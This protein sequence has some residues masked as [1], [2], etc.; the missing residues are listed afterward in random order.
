MSEETQEVAES[1]ETTTTDANQESNEESNSTGDGEGEAS[2]ESSEQRTT[3]TPDQKRGRLERQLKQLNK[4]HPK[5]SQEDNQEGGEEGSKEDKGEELN[6]RFLV[7]DLKGE[8]IKGKKEQDVVLD[9]IKES[10]LVGNDVGVEDALKS[11]VVKEALAGIKAKAG[12]PSPSK[13]TGN[14]ANDSFEYW[15]KEAKKGHF[16]R[17]DKAMMQRLSKARIFTS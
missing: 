17:E 4:K 6:R 7:Q 3:E 2:S 9:Y 11:L 16:P 15:V 13:R 12:V 8:G 1:A 10:K 14:G 5:E